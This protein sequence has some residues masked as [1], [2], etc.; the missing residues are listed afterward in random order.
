M[1]GVYF[2]NPGMPREEERGTYCP[3]GVKIAEF[4]AGRPSE[5]RVIEPWQCD[6]PWC[7]REQ[8]EQARAEMEADLAEAERHARGCVKEPHHGGSCDGE[9]HPECL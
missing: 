5:A 4:P 1:R 3:E 8:F 9:V 2:E 7:T 6:K